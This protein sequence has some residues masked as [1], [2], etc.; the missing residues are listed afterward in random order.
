MLLAYVS[1]ACPTMSDDF[2]AAF[3]AAQA[4]RGLAAKPSKEQLKALKAKKA[5]AAAPQAAR[6]QPAA[7]AAP[8]G[9]QPAAAGSG[10]GGA[11]AA[12]V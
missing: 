11:A 7:A 6:Q 4:Q 3:R 1:S 12:A 8:R 2:K 5:A 10:R 9:A